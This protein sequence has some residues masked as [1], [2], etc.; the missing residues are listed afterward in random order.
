L[1]MS[2]I[3]IL[4]ISS[5][6]LSIISLNEFTNLSFGQQQQYFT[7]SGG[8]SA[9]ANAL[10]EQQQMIAPI[11]S[12]AS[13]SFTAMDATTSCQKLPISN[14]AASGSQ[15]GNPPSNAIDNNLTT[16]WT[17]HGLGSWIQTDLGAKMTIC[18]VDVAWYRGNLRQN[19]FVISVSNDTNTFYHIFS[20]KSSGTTLS[21]ERY[22]FPQ[23]F[24]RYVRI[25]VNGN[26]E[27]TY[28]S[29]TEIAVNG[30]AGST[31]NP[32]PPP[33][34]G[35]PPAGG[36]DKFGIKEIYATK[37]GGGEQ[38]FMNMQ[39]PTHDTQTNPPSMTKNSDGSYKIKSTSVRFAVFTSSGFH[40]N[41]IATYDQ[42]QLIAKGYMQSPNDWKNVEI[43][44]YFKLNSFTSSTTNGPAHIELLARGG[45]HTSTQGCEGTAYH[46]NTYQTGRAKFEKELEHTAGYTTNDPQKTGATSTL[47]GRGWIGV[48]AVFYTMPNGSVKLEQWIDDSTNN[49][50]TPGNNWHKLLEFTDSGNWGGG[51][52]SCGGTPNTII[53]WGGP[54]VHF[55][56]DNIDDMDIKNFSVREIQPP[57]VS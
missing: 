44:G 40:P 38:W 56:W 29:A 42:K 23:I 26:T 22:S 31:T 53:T 10:Q 50:N 24:A 1:N 35:P 41:Q 16:R 12:E 43:T 7:N 36:V 9:G 39:D 51:H 2:C 25:T 54:I 33:P 32:P 48:K 52:P 20:G 13:P 18:S 15:S 27:N 28:A 21:Y 5:L 8:L 17:N 11:R 49:I 45:R 37:P 57:A 30:F 14:I 3:S 6:L 47:Q 19:N 46:S 4:V 34:P 55:R